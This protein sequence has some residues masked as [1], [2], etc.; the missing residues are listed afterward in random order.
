MA[1]KLKASG[2]LRALANHLGKEG[3]VFSRERGEIRIWTQFERHPFE[4]VGFCHPM[5]YH[6]ERGRAVLAMRCV[7]K[8][9]QAVF[10]HPEAI[11]AA[12]LAAPANFVQRFAANVAGG[13]QLGRNCGRMLG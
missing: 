6:V 13:I 11:F 3:A 5:I 10:G 9:G 2:F 12:A 1:V 8:L 7:P 4:F